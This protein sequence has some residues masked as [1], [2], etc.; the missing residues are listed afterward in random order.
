MDARL[1]SRRLAPFDPADVPDQPQLVARIRAEIAGAGPMTFARFMELALYDPDF[2]YYR[3]IEDRPS[4]AG[5][6]LTSPEAHPIFGQAIGRQVEDVWERLGRPEGFLVREYGAGSGALAVAMLGELERPGGPAAGRVRYEAIEINQHRRHALRERLT[7]ADLG[8]QP[9]VRAPDGKPVG[10]AGCV[11]ANEFLDALPV[12]RV[13]QRAGRLVEVFV[14]WQDGRFIDREAAPS[15]TSLAARLEREGVELADGQRAELC[16]GIDA[17]LD[18]VAADLEQGAVIV[19]DYGRPA[20]QLYSGD[21]FDGTVRGYVRHHATADP[22]RHVGSQDLTA[23]VDFTAVELAAAD[24]GLDVLGSTSQA[25]FLVGA[26]AEELLE[27]VRADAATDLAAWV[28]LRSALVRMLDPRAMGAFRVLLLGRGLPS[29]APL[30]G[31]A[32]G[33]GR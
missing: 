2:G 16:P 28:D 6:F 27:R 17:W 7:D 15:T 12:H 29:D 14:D 9:S 23:H 24:R 13:V 25:A 1:D 5:D 4:R 31:L 30:R 10:F 18:E 26:G 3:S 32:G 11:I 21:R 33:A 8:G 22:Y 19:I 20:I